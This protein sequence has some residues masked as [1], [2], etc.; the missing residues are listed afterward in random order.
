MVA[1]VALL[2]LL[3][4]VTAALVP[5]HDPVPADVDAVVV[6]GGG[7]GERLALGRALADEHGAA[8]V[9]SSFWAIALGHA[10][11]LVC[12]VEVRC[13]HPRPLSTA[14]EAAGTAA[15]ADERGW[16][17]VAVATSSFHV[18]RTRML[19]EQ[20]LDEVAVRGAAAPGHLG[21]QVYRRVRELAAGL[22]GLTVARA[23]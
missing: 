2:V 20:C 1:A 14:G 22:A 23:C 15:L 21:V 16:E 17:S 7:Q 10:E 6:L 9:L 4:A 3:A 13:L 19:F 5:R 12:D 8:L 11:G 18:N